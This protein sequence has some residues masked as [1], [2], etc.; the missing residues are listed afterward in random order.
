M[1]VAPL[2][3]AAVVQY[4][5]FLATASSAAAAHTEAEKAVRHLESLAEDLSELTA[6]ATAFSDGA[7]ELVTWRSRTKQLQGVSKLPGIH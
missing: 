2:Q 3:E 5:S 6:T 4:S 7:S 1:Q